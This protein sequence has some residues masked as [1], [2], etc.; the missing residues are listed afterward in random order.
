MITIEK[1]NISPDNISNWFAL[2]SLCK[3]SNDSKS[4]NLSSVEFGKLL[5]LSQQTASRRIN[6]LE[7]LGWITR[8]IEGKSQDITITQKGINILFGV[9]ENLKNI[10]V[11]IL[12]VGEVTEGMHEGA[13]YVSIKGY[14]EQFKG[15]LGF[16]PYKGTL[17]LKL[18]DTD[19]KILKEQMNHI[20]P[21][22]IKGFKDQNR[23]YGPVFCYDVYISPLKSREKIRKAA[24]LDIKRTHHKE[25]II[26][27]LAKPF[28]RDY[29]DL[30]NGDQ[31]VIKLNNNPEV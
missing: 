15:K 6:D 1:H 27:I 25:N 16:E 18:T 2:Y 26:E 7:D 9:Y 30:N 13:Y 23:E 19:L 22:V 29:F 4:I 10:L 20:K 14:Y 8:K 11:K 24:I 28:L 21:I 31:V 3:H 17:N 5:N 12:I